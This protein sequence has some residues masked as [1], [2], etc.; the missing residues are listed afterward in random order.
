MKYINQCF[1]AV[2]LKHEVS[3][4]TTCPVLDGTLR[5]RRGGA[6]VMNSYEKLKYSETKCLDFS[7]VHIEQVFL[8]FAIAGL[9]LDGL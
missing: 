1:L 4:C 9:P 6:N 8:L 3:K 5:S 7:P 2:I